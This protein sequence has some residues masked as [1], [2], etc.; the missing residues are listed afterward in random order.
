MCENILCSTWG[1]GRCSLLCRLVIESLVKTAPSGIPQSSSR[2][3]SSFLLRRDGKCAGLSEGI[4]L[5]RDMLKNSYFFINSGH[6]PFRLRWIESFVGN[7]EG[8]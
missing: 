6:F 3:S 1:K 4:M 2:P 7:V 8:Q 5:L